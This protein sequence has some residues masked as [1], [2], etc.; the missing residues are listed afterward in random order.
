MSLSKDSFFFYVVL[1]LCFLGVHLERCWFMLTDLTLLKAVRLA[2]K[3]VNV[4]SVV[5]DGTFQ[6]SEVKRNPFPILICLV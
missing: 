2:F 3:S 4:S 1:F 6:N 5:I